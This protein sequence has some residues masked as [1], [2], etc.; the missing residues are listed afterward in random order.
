MKSG[1]R[2]SAV[3]GM[4]YSADP[5]ELNSDIIKMLDDAEKHKLTGELTSII[6]PHAGY[7]YSGLTAAHAYKLIEG[8]QFESVIIISPS[9]REYFRGISIFNGTAYR[10]PL[11]DLQIDSELRDLLTS[12]D[13]IIE[14]SLQGHGKEH[15]IEIQL[16]FLQILLKNFSLLPIVIGDQRSE[17]C[18]HLG[19]RLTEVLKDR[20]VLIVASTDLSHFH[21]Y[22]Q[23]RKLDQIVIDSVSRFDYKGLMKELEYEKAEACGGGPTVAAML[24]AEQLGANQIDILHKCN[25]GD[26]TGEHDSVVGYFSAAITKTK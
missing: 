5:E 24:A 19:N 23:A 25:S 20:N 9:H 16:P 14:S 17:N 22:D 6:V 26:I 21:S 3:A 11:G 15:A 4:F 12:S 2:Q 10:T 13:R 8:K 18:F 7:Q 1:I